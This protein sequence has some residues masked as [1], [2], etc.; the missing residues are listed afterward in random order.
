VPEVDQIL[1]GW[2]GSKSAREETMNIKTLFQR[3]PAA[4]YF[5]LTYAISWG[6]SFA[7]GAPK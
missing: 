5:V 7:V 4:A 6:G 2:F 3:Y 1:N